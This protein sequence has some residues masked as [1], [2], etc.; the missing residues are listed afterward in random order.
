[1]ESKD[2]NQFLVALGSNLGDRLRFLVSSRELIAERIGPILSWAEPIE[3]NPLGP[4]DQQFLNTALICATAADPT[5]VMAILL[6][7]ETALGRIRRQKWGNR[8]IDLD[9]IL[10]K[11]GA[12]RSP[13]KRQFLT[14]NFQ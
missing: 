2:K 6:E 8:T 13:E 4:A 9:L 1:M 3:T 10:C 7:I 14:Q 11:P 12:E 5:T